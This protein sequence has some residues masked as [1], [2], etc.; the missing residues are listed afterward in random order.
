MC[1]SFFEEVK[2]TSKKILDVKVLGSFCSGGTKGGISGVGTP[3]L[4]INALERGIYLELT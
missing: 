2:W 4:T 1:K 3:F